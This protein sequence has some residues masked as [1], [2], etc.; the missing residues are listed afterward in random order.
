MVGVLGVIL[1]IVCAVE[2]YPQKIVDSEFRRHITISLD[3]P[4][5]DDWVSPPP[6]IYMKYYLF[7]V[8]N[9]DDI[10]NGK[11][12]VVKEIGPYTYRMKVPRYDITFFTNSTVS[13]RFNHTLIFEPSMSAGSEDDILCHANMP[14]ATVA[15]MMEKMDLPQK[16]TE[17]FAKIVEIIGERDLFVKHTAKEILFGYKDPFFEMLHDLLKLIGVNY[18]PYF[19]PFHGFNNTDDGL[20]LS[21]TGKDDYSMTNELQRW[22][23]VELLPYWSTDNANMINGTDGSFFRPY[24]KK[25]EVR[26]MFFSD[27]C[28]SLKL[29]FEK[30]S[31]VK[32]VDTLRF[33]F[34]DDLLANASI[35]PENEGFCVPPGN[36]L[37]SGVMTT[38]PCRSGAPVFLS[39][40]HFYNAAPQY[41]HAVD[42]IN[43]RKELHD[44]V[45]D[46]E[47]MSGVVFHSS[48]SLQINLQIKP[49]IYITQMKN[50]E[51]FLCPALWLAGVSTMDDGVSAQFRGIMKVVTFMNIVSYLTI[52][53]F[54][55]VFI[56]SSMCTRK[57]WRKRSQT[58]TDS[59][60][61]LS[62]KD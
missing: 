48:R 53:V 29:T 7:N 10:I 42:G 62:N 49:S 19:G 33:H 60:R 58:G 21:T 54:L 44:S 45:F 22:N 26:Y 31:S 43:P 38:A 61:L 11:K 12:A 2:R 18:D 56:A 1:G 46:V 14:L 25:D 47:P 4:V 40:P 41:I 8:T 15:E 24:V 36:C 34:A 3:S 35:Q 23:G 5:Y 9:P 32:G 20:Y 59:E 27:M 30:E 52:G 28:R 6:P 50:V 55:I 13:F 16:Q 39:L 51:T 57:K 37:D 17:I